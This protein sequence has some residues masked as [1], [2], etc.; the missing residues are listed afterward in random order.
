MCMKFWD[1]NGDHFL[2]PVRLEDGYDS[3]ILIPVYLYTS[4]FIYLIIYK[5]NNVFFGHVEN[6]YLKNKN[7]ISFGRLFLGKI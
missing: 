6:T 5:I 2:I 1:G 3:K 4:I 7:F